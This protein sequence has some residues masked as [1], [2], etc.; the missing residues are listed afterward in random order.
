LKIAVIIDGP[1]SDFGYNYQMQH[2]SEIIQEMY[3]SQVEILTSSGITTNTIACYNE[4]VRYINLG[5]QAFVLPTSLYTTCA[6]MISDN[7][8]HMPILLQS[9]QPLSPSYPNISVIFKVT[10]L[11]DIR[12]MVGA[13]VGKQKNVNTVCF[14][15]NGVINNALCKLWS[16]V[17]YL[18]VMSTNNTGLKYYVAEASGFDNAT[19]ELLIFNFFKSVHCDVII[20]Q[21]NSF[22][23]H[24][25]AKTEDIYSVAWSSDMRQF[26]GE[27]VLT[28]VRKNWEV[29]MSEF[30]NDIFAG[31]YSAHVYEDSYANHGVDLAPLS[32][33]VSPAAASYLR[34][35]ERKLS[36]GKINVFCGAD[37]KS[38]FG[39]D[40]TTE[41][42]L[43]SIYLPNIVVVN[44]KNL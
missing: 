25:L 7:H 16:N 27:T 13:L 24:M 41:A 9:S 23:L 12:Y 43:S 40:C 18:G 44:A 31:N 2:S 8:G 15:N 35:V 19:Q 3:G 5:V 32:N 28:S 42:N 30:I 33:R 10:G 21:L 36:E 22:Y 37:V 38:H 1:L 20:S 6:R 39:T 14:A 4:A 17:Q 26:I 29:P 34:K 11:N